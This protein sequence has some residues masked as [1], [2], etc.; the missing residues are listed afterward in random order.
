ME[1]LPQQNKRVAGDEIPEESAISAAGKHVVVLGGGDTGSDCIG[2]S[3]RHGAKSVTSFELLPKP[4]LERAPNNP[5]PEWSRIQR[6][7]SSHHE[8]GTLDYNIL[9][10]KFTGEN[11]VVKKLHAVRIEWKKDKDG[12]FVFKEIP[13]SEF[14]VNADLVFLALGFVSP[15]Q[16]GMIEQLGVE[17]DPRGNVKVD[18]NN[19]TS[20]EGVFAAGDMETG[21]SL[22]VK[23]IKRGRIAA[24]GVDKYLMGETQLP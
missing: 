22:V 24:R 5:W 12:R 10:K 13:G 18:E 16:A 2:T 9:T 7:S 23:A 17:L 14:S 15:V 19:M 20:K 8:G 3:H 1:F 6:L 11:G 4:P 21:Q